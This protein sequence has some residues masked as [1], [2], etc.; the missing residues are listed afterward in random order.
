MTVS[1]EIETR[2]GRPPADVFEAL[3]AVERYPEWLIASGIVKVERLDPG[4]L[5]TG[6]RASHLADRR[7]PLD[8]ARW[9][10]HGLIAG[11]SFG[12]RGKDKDGVSIEIDALLA[13]TGRRRACAGRS[14]SGCRCATG[15]S[16]RWSRRRRSE[17]PR[18]TSRRSSVGWSRSPAERCRCCRRDPRTR[19]PLRPRRRDR[20]LRGARRPVLRRGRGRTRSSG[21]STR[22]RTSAGASHRLTLFLIQYWGGPTTYDDERG[23]PRL[24]MRHAPVRDRAGRA[25]PLARPHA[26]RDRGDGARPPTSPPSWS[27]TSRW[28]PRRCATATERCR[29]RSLCAARLVDAGES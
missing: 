25:R 8:D 21:R 22:S 16:N 3:A 24:R 27:A 15:C 13:R 11:T 28:P 26:R 23:H 20:L 9:Q 4:P 7:R 12:L 17:P 29:H 5:A 1:V 14:G 2:I 10:H 19:D 18:S 6:S